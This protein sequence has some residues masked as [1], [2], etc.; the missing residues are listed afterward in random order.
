MNI[1]FISILSGSVK[2][3]IWI[4]KTILWNK[5][6]IKFNIYFLKQNSWTYD[7]GTINLKN[8][9][10]QGQNGSYIKNSEW[11]LE[12]KLILYYIYCNFKFF[13]IILK[14]LDQI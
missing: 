11:Y 12:S 3:W 10:D 6:W 8:K 4:K 2:A 9:S 5:N 14:K 13:Y 1:L 7:E